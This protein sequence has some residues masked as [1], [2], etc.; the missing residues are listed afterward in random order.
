MESTPK[1]DRQPQS[2]RQLTADKAGSGGRRLYT[3]PS[4]VSYGDVRD[5]TMGTSVGVTDSGGEGKIIGT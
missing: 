1:L 3:P 2:E 4:L 5:L